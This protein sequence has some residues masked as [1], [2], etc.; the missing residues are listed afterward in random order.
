MSPPK[1]KGVFHFDGSNR[2]VTPL[3]RFAPCTLE[4]WV[5]PKFYPKKDSQFVIGS[6]IPTKHGLSLGICEAVLCAEYI[7]G[8][9]F[10]GAAVPLDRWSHV[11]AVFGESETRLYLDGR[12]VGVGPATKA[13]GGTTFVIGNVGRDNPINY[14]VGGVRSVRVTKGER[15]KA[16]FVPDPTFAKDIEDAPVKAVLIYDG[17]AV[18]GDRVIDLSGAGSHGRWERMPP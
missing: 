15:Y 9:T 8:V 10:A 6:D 16:D 4:A 11:A 17:A 3:E 2:I 18:E 5:Q 12:K 7:P 14:F 13:E 1:E